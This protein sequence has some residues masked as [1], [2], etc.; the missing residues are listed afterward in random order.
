MLATQLT[1]G[2]SEGSPFL[3]S[4]VEDAVALGPALDVADIVAAR[5]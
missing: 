2:A 4:A 1:A 3:A 5:R